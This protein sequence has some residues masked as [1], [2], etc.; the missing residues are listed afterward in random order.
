MST[1]SFART[2][3]KLNLN[4]I[5]VEFR[6]YQ[7]SGDT[8]FLQLRALSF[9]CPDG[10]TPIGNFCTV[11][12][13]PGRVRVECPPNSRP[14]GNNVCELLPLQVTVQ[15]HDGSRPDAYNRCRLRANDT[16]YLTPCPLN[17]VERNGKCYV[18]A[19]MTYPIPTIEYLCPRNFKRVGD[20]CIMDI[21]SIETHFRCP[22]NTVRQ[23]ND[24]IYRVA[25]A[26]NYN[27]TADCPINSRYIDRK[28]CEGI[29]RENVDMT[30]ERIIQSPK[31]CKKRSCS[32]SVTSIH[33]VNHVYIPTNI[34]STNINTINIGQG[35][36]SCEGSSCNNKN[37]TTKPCDEKPVEVEEK[38]CC[39]VVTPRVCEN[40]QGDWQC[41]H[42]EYERCGP[43]CVQDVIHLKASRPIYRDQM[44]VMPPPRYGMR[45]HPRHN[46]HVNCYGCLNGRYDCSPECYVS[47]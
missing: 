30:C 29:F 37:E 2:L 6:G 8:C 38:K 31:C 39:T 1:V 36:S 16:T 3:S 26:K 35:S 27:V 33:N 23:G 47:I 42:R 14:I 7:R 32:R 13:P 45:V 43:M 18:E 22:E 4:Q 41:G 25:D 34:T 28:G 15:C 9:R 19:R 10:T 11:K 21:P 24:C 46:E 44:L 20:L 5:C 12:V 40:H 17:S